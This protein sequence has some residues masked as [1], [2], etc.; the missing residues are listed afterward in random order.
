MTAGTVEAAAHPATSHQLGEIADLYRRALAAIT[1]HRGGLLFSIGLVLP[2]PLETSLDQLRVDDDHLLLAGTFAGALVGFASVRA[3]PLAMPGPSLTLSVL[4]CLWV[5]PEAREVGVGSALLHAV[6]A[7]A[8]ARHCAG[9]DASA[10][11]G[12]RATKAFFEGHHLRARLVV[13]H[14]PFEGPLGPGTA[15]PAS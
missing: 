8:R 3:A 13:M 4:E 10:L 11:P 14:E 5:I 15:S 9:L 7:W 1:P 2:E 12:D 6:R